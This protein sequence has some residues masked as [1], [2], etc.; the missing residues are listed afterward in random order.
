MAYELDALISMEQRTDIPEFGS[1]DT[2]RVHA[3][4]VEGDKERIQVFEG[5]VIR[6]RMKGLVSN[7]T[8]R[9]LAS[10]VGVE[11]PK[12]HQDALFRQTAARTY[13][14]VATERHFHR[15]AHRDDGRVLS[16]GHGSTIQTGIQV[17]AGCPFRGAHGHPGART[18][19]FHAHRF[20]HD[21]WTT[22]NTMWLGCAAS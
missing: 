3:K 20:A 22:G 15:Y 5:V 21:R 14:G 13:L 4:V 6:K 7:F 11:R 17:E 16:E 19:P 10:G 9:K 18:E 2:V 1:G 8:V 12:C